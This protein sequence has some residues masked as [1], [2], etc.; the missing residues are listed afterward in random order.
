MLHDDF[1]LIT[2]F[3]WLPANIPCTRHIYYYDIF[4]QYWITLQGE[5]TTIGRTPII[6][7]D[8]SLDDCNPTS[9]NLHAAKS[10]KGPAAPVLW[11]K[12]CGQV[13]LQRLPMMRQAKNT[14]SENILL[15]I[16]EKCTKC[17]LFCLEDFCMTNFIFWF[18]R[19]RI[20][21]ICIEKRRQQRHSPS[22]QHLYKVEARKHHAATLIWRLCEGYARNYAYKLGVT[23]VQAR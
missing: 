7:R 20:N 19:K 11:C 21:E 8:T 3:F 2:S 23:I 16:E 4:A 22:P 15:Y 5:W 18:Q 17:D 6:H 13:W 14:F 10:L 9:H 12:R 1:Q